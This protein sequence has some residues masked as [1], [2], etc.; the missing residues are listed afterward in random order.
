MSWLNLFGGDVSKSVEVIATEWIETDK[1]KA[2]AQAVMVKALDPNGKLRR[3]IGYT[4]RTLVTGFAGLMTLLILC[5]AFGGG[6]GVETAITNLKELFIPFVEMFG[7]I[8][9]ASFGVN[10]VNAYKGG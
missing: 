7:M 5:Q 10:A 3:D 2:E 1:E 9:M 4:L 8:T 6:T